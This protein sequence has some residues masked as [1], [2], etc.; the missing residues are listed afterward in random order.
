MVGCPRQLEAVRALLAAVEGVT[1]VV[2]QDVDVVVP[3][4]DLLGDPANVRLHRHVGDEQYRRFAGCDLG[5]LRAGALALVSFIP[6]ER[7]AQSPLVP[8]HIPRD[9]ARGA[10][11]SV[12][13]S[14]SA[15]FSVLL[16][17]SYFMQ[18]NLGFSPLTT[19][20]AFLPMTAAITATFVQTRVLHRTGPKPMVILGMALAL[21]G[22]A[23]LT[24]LGP[25]AG[26]GGDVLP[27]LILVGLGMGTVFAP[28][29]GTATLGVETY[30]A[31]IASALL[32]TSQQVGG[33]IGTALL[34]TVFAGA[35]AGFAAAHPHL[36]HLVTTAQV[37]GEATAF[38]WLTGIYALGLLVAAFVLPA[39][40]T[41]RRPRP[42]PLVAPALAVCRSN[43][44]ARE[45][46]AGLPARG[47]GSRRWNTE[48]RFGVL[49]E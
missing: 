44:G 26:Y 32:N 34:G 1:R 37:H 18:R 3:I 22:S 47:P 49:L 4:A 21:T 39:P 6:V 24:R 35:T 13:L 14:F 10:Y 41:W 43:R 17:L 5:D 23:L 27:S 16:F 25:H 40:P 42:R 31:G 2:D 48:R 7:R 45:G 11:L 19:G 8:L 28:S 30:E 33:S 20:V 29:L 12:L 15:V 38:W 36:A 46:R 9:R